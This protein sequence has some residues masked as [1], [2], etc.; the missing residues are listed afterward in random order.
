MDDF[1]NCFDVNDEE[2]N[3][4]K[5]VDLLRLER[6]SKNYEKSTFVFAI[7]MLLLYTLTQSSKHQLGKKRDG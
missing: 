4:E 6:N 2:Q 3:M 7:Q 5:A 1:K